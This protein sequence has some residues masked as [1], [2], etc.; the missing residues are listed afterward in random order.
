M[1]ESNLKLSDYVNFVKFIW[2]SMSFRLKILILITIVLSFLFYWYEYRPSHIRKE[3]A[4]EIPGN[5]HIRPAYE[6]WQRIFD[7][8]IKSKGLDK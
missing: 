2:K 4:S 8:C 1:Q 6:A 7:A 5:I 3:C